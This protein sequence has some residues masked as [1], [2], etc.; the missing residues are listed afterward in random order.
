M[1]REYFWIDGERCDA[2]GIRLQRPLTFEGTT[3]KM[4]TVDVP[5]RNGQ[6]HYYEGAYT[7]VKGEASCFSLRKYDVDKALSAVTRYTLMEPGYHRLETTEEPEI[8]RKATVVTGPG[9]EIRMRV[10]APFELEF[11]CMPQKFLKS[12]DREIKLASSG[13]VLLNEWF[14]SLP[15]INVTGAGEGTLT[16][17]DAIVTFKSTFSGPVVLDCELQDAYN[18]AEN[19]N[20]QI[21]AA[22]FPVLPHGKCTVTWTG[23]ITGVSIIPRWWTL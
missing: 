15:I 22:K 4:E 3:P 20:N 9:T 2:V 8:Y 21:S 13:A 17:N 6:L 11:D 1:E 12:G 7:N 5:G 19:K 16:I 23:G 14:P 18:G 10:L